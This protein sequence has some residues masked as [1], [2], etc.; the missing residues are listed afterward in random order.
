MKKFLFF[1]IFMI[2]LAGAVFF[3]GWA[4][5]TVL[6]GS[7]GVMRSKT[8]GLEA[9]TIRDGEFRWYW[10]K[11]I[12]TNANVMVFTVSPVNRTIRNTGTL[13]SGDLYA[14]LAGLQAD[15]SWEIRGELNFTINP[16]YLPLLSDRENIQDNDGLR[17]V[18]ENLAI[19]IE[20]IVVQHLRTFTDSADAEMLESLI[21]ASTLP[22]LESA[23]QRD[24]PE[25]ENFACTIQLVRYPD[26]EL[27][28]SL[29]ALY[30][31]YLARQFAV[32]S[33]DITREAEQR[34]TS[35]MRMDELAQY[36]ELL[37]RYPILLDYL[38]IERDLLLD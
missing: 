25:I 11:V 16:D 35:R 5:L 18:E 27:Y 2:L 14:S 20:N 34:I 26:F 8:H 3:L 15:F 28:Q 31:E 6:P 22:D 19:R 36:G 7:F 21:P 10:Y 32:L 1:L 33:Q 4:H 38:R 30:Q 24:F 9:E 17:R 23:V 29:K 12:P 37:T 13:P